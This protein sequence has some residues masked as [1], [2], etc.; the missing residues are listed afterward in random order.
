[1]VICRPNQV[2]AAD[3]TYIPVI[4]GHG[5]LFAIMDWYSRYVLEWQLSNMLDAEFCVEA[6][7]RALGKA[8]PEIFNTDQGVQF[9]SLRFTDCLTA[10]NIRISMDGKGRAFDNIMVER[11]WRSAK[12]EHIYPSSYEKLQDVK[13]G[14]S[15]YFLF[16]N[17]S[18]PH[19]GL[20]N[21]TPKEVYEKGVLSSNCR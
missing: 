3:I 10:S 21:R 15:K 5:Y 2:W 9:T 20:K 7:Q 13:V 1:M 4:G 17:G 14:L 11:L 12:Y 6:L 16:Y 19:Q 18:R 8:T